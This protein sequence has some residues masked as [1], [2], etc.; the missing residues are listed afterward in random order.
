MPALKEQ[1]EKVTSKLIDLWRNFSIREK[2]MA[3]GALLVLL[4]IGTYYIY[5]PISIIYAK[6]NLELDRLRSDLKMLPDEV[7]KY[8]KMNNRKNEIEA[9]YK[10][11]ELTEGAAS[12]IEQLI[13]SKAEITD[14]RN[15]QI[16]PLN[17]KEFGGNY[18]Q[19]PFRVELKIGSMAKLVDFLNEIVNGDKPLLL[20]KLDI[21]KNAH[22]DFLTVEMD[23]S[24]IKKSSE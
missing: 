13:K 14:D 21:N 17:P 11:I 20:A 2:V 1:L 24:N 9:A 22:G 12:H 4:G 6:Q 10:E 19:E 5:E 16:K 8:L 7:D 15:F 3:I 23:V 18:T